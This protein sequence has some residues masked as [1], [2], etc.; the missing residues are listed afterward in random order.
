MGDCRL[1]EEH[2]EA[3]ALASDRHARSATC[4]RSPGDLGIVHVLMSGGR[5]VDAPAV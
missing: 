5:W 3:G 2:F 4:R 1:T